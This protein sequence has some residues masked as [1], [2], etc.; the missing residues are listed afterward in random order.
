MRNTPP[1]EFYYLA[2]AYFH[3]DFA[4]LYGDLRD[5]TEDVADG[6]K[7]YGSTAVLKRYIEHEIPVLSDAELTNLW[8]STNAQIQLAG[9]TEL[10]RVLKD[11]ATALKG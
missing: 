4:V 3:Q 9:P 8:A 11:I 2:E 10:R 1:P 6:F 7:S 5:L